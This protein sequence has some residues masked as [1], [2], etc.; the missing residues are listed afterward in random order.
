MSKIRLMK[1]NLPN[2]YFWCPHFNFNNQ[3]L[4]VTKKVNSAILFQHSD[5]DPLKEII[6]KL[7]KIFKFFENPIK[8]KETF[9]RIKILPGKNDIKSPFQTGWFVC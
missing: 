2:V 7:E 1:I 9:C 3:N 8:E 6:K 5:P 4:A